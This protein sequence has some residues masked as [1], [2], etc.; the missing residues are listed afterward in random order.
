M[1]E[2][3]KFLLTDII[4]LLLKHGPESFSNL[5]KTIS[6]GRFVKELESILAETAR[7]GKV[8]S[9]QSKKQQTKKPIRKQLFEL[10]KKQPEKGQILLG[11]YDG[12]NAKRYLQNLR[13]I[14]EFAI[15]L[16]LP[17]IKATSRDRA[18]GPLIR[19]LMK[20]SVSDLRVIC[21]EMNEEKNQN[22]DRSL[23]GWSKLILHGPG[24]QQST[25]QDSPSNASELE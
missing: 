19:G 12:L 7:S 16:K 11:F 15:E 3:A 2:K 10:T 8:L 9:S 13:Q 20:L 5:S 22:D 1:D 18:L 17:T 24:Y 6:D 14:R 25:G 4:K 23:A 21:K